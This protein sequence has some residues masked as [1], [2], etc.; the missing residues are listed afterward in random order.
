MSD[1]RGIFLYDL[2]RK[3]FPKVGVFTNDDKSIWLV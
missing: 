1:Y 3:Y 2:K